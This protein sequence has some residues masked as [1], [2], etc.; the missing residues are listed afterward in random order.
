[1]L[2]RHE[3]QS[4]VY[5]CYTNPQCKRSVQGRGALCT[6]SR[7]RQKREERQGS[8]QLVN[9]RTASLLCL[10]HSPS[11]GVHE[12]QILC[13][14]PKQTLFYSI[15]RREKVSLALSVTHTEVRLAGVAPAPYLCTV[16][17]SRIDGRLLCRSEGE[18]RVNQ[19]ATGVPVQSPEPVFGLEP[20]TC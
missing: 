17:V 12:K 3:S 5:Y 11:A 4:L 18:T 13:G 20:K 15:N 1:M 16:S 2:L 7:Q 14:S 9:H 8:F 6:R 10:F 19:V